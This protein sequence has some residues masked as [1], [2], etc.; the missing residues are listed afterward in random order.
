[1]NQAELDKEI[2]KQLDNLVCP[3]CKIRFEKN[4][5]LFHHLFLKHESVVCEI[6]D[7]AALGRRSVIKE[8]CKECGDFSN[9]SRKGENKLNKLFGGR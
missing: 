3:F 4:R 6:C 2:S 5:Q 7:N 9:F 1:M 8:E